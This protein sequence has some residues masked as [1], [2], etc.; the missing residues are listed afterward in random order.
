MKRLCFLVCILLHTLP[1]WSQI[2]NIETL[3]RQGELDSAFTLTE[4]RLK[5]FP[6]DPAGHL[7]L[8]KLSSDGQ[9]VE[10]HL[11]KLLPGSQDFPQREEAYFR[12]GL[13]YYA[14]GNYG[15][16]ISMFRKGL[17]R[18]PD[19]PWRDQSLY[20]MGQACLIYGEQ[21]SKDYL[22][23]AQVYY[24]KLRSLSQSDDFYRTFSWEGLAKTNLVL[25]KNTEAISLL[26]SALKSAPADQKS[27]LLW[28]GWKISQNRDTVAAR[29]YLVTLAKEFPNSLEMK[30]LRE[31]WP[32]A[33]SI[34]HPLAQ[35]VHPK[36]NTNE[37]NKS[38][39]TRKENA[40]PKSIVTMEK[41]EGEFSLQL[42][43]YSS[44]ENAEK[45]SKELQ[46]KGFSNKLLAKE[47]GQT[48]VVKI[49]GFSSRSEALAF[50][51]NKLKPKGI[52]RYFPV[53]ETPQ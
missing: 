18:N 1:S 6:S 30:Y 15:L 49:T 53:M 48:F 38:S 2:D 45:R 23:S 32:A 28:L 36:P 51:E 41:S 14:Q 47:G 16:S 17:S 9:S 46:D 29:T 12:L 19:G 13:L 31:N 33:L 24:S 25:K 44:R 34:L 5:E 4:E 7:L 42:G 21:K 20:W 37:V 43:A 10:S 3:A 39:G 22:D 35:A 26:D 50:A 40:T 11:K 52:E 8:A 27:H